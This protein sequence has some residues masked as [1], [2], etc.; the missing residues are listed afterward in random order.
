MS[1]Q[2]FDNAVRILGIAIYMVVVLDCESR[3]FRFFQPLKVLGSKTGSQKD[4]HGNIHLLL[5]TKVDFEPHMQ[6]YESE[7]ANLNGE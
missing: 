2:H 6:L 5:T 3:G 1:L 7:P 4:Q